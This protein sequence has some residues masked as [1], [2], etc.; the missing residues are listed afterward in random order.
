MWPFQNLFREFFVKVKICGLTRLEDALLAHAL[1]ASELG[2][3]LCESARRASV[4]MVQTILKGLP[5]SA[6]T[7]GVFNGQPLEEVLRTCEKVLLKC[8]QLHHQESPEFVSVIK[9]ERP[10]LKIIKTIHARGHEFSAPPYNYA[11]CD[12]LLFELKDFQGKIQ[13]P[14]PFYLAGGIE[15]GNVRRLIEN[16]RP[17]GVD[18][19]RG[20]ESSPGIKDHG[21]MRAFFKALEGML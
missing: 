8:V 5:A 7:I 19:A 12:E 18:L 1:G 17:N 16:H 14:L 20:V 9:K 2:F 11:H 15:D 3:V 4:P 6:G 13:G 10:D 21:K